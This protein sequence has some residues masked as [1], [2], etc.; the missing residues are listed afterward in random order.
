MIPN[1]DSTHSTEITT[2]MRQ[3]PGWVIGNGMLLVAGVFVVLTIIAG[4]IKVPVIVRPVATTIKA[5]TPYH[6]I[7]EVQLPAHE[8]YTGVR[9]V[10]LSVS[11]IEMKGFLLHPTFQ[12]HT[13]QSRFIQ[14]RIEKPHATPELYSKLLQ[15]ESSKQMQL[16]INYESLLRRLIL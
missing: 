16:T 2:I 8:N 5:N 10:L 14:I 11:G 12:S 9:T 1:E 13:N 4:V 3:K 6:Y 7:I 15:P